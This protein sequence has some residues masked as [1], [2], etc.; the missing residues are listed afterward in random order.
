MEINETELDKLRKELVILDGLDIKPNY[1][2]LARK[3][4]CDWRTVKKYHNGYEGKSKTRIKLSKLDK[5]KD[6]I[7]EKFTLSGVTISAVYQY[8]LSIDPNIGIYSNFYSY[9]KKHD[10]IPK[11]KI[12]KVHPRFE[13]PLGKQLQFDWKEDITLYNKYNIPF[14]FNVFSA[15]LG[16]SRLHVFRYSKT[17]ARFDVQRCLIETFKF[18]A[19]VPKEILTD[20]MSCIFDYS[21]RQFAS[22]FKHFCK[23]MGTVPKHCK[24]R[25]SNTK[26]KVESSNRF[27]QWLIPYNYEFETEED[28]INII[29]TITKKV[30]TSINQTTGVTPIMLFNKEKEYLLPLPNKDLLN[31]YLDDTKTVKVSNGFLVYFRGNQY[32]VPPKF[33]NKTVQLK[34]QDNKLYI[35]HNTNLIAMHDISSKKIN[36]LEEHYKIGMSQCFNCTYDNLEQKVKDNLALFDKLSN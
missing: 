7:K 17:K 35:Y 3:H 13:T 28:L 1:A 11:D 21:K 26:G 15:T 20:N 12:S 24:V 18:I 30:N 23:D 27:M 19:G 36:Y 16:T 22:D 9:V 32:S 8:I 2:Q 29:S 6:I 31:S 10:L 14:T 34:E 4:N 5:Y 33:A 25:T